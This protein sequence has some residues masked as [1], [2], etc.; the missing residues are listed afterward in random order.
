MTVSEGMSVHVGCNCIVSSWVFVLI[1]FAYSSRFSSIAWSKMANRAT[2]Y[3]YGLIAAGMV[4]GTINV[5]DPAKL[6]A[7][8]D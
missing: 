4:D 1:F 8:H 3:S 6:L 2:D 7:D 5:W